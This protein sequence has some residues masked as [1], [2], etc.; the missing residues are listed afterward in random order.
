MQSRNGKNTVQIT[1]A[2]S[3][4]FHLLFH[5]LLLLDLKVEDAILPVSGY[6]D[7]QCLT[8]IDEEFDSNPADGKVRREEFCALLFRSGVYKYTDKRLQKIV[9][10]LHHAPSMGIPGR[11]LHSNLGSHEKL[12]QW[13]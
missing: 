4:L 1:D 2:K 3:A 6:I 12:A 5:L 10:I 11:Y 9:F 7:C 8:S 13:R